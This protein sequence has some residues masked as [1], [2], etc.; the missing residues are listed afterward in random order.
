MSQLSEEETKSTGTN[1]L[2]KNE[3]KTQTTD[4]KNKED[5]EE[6]TRSIDINTDDRER[7]DWKSKYPPEARRE[8]KF[9]AIYLGIIFLLSFAL[10]ILNYFCIP[11][12]LYTS[13]KLYLAQFRYMA[14]FSSAGMLGGTVFGVKYFYRIVARGYWTQDRRYW[15]I[16]S[17]FI[18]MTVAFIVGSMVSAGMLTSQNSSTNAWA[19]AFGF[20]AGYFADEAV[21]KMYEFATL[22]FGRTTRK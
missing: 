6:K 9:E 1:N 13:I 17:P 20:F 16:F 14:Y 19:V 4:T 8:I 5:S 3:E 2:E 7:F 12:P 21:G 18:S 22:L 15:R 11:E 10:L